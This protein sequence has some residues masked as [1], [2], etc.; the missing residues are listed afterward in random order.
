MSGFKGLVPVYPNRP[1]LPSWQDSDPNSH[2]I[3]Q[4]FID[5]R[6]GARFNPWTPQQTQGLGKPVTSAATNY[7]GLRRFTPKPQVDNSFMSNKNHGWFSPLDWQGASV[8]TEKERALLFESTP[9]THKA[10]LLH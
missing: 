9:L 4:A 5:A 2:S 6:G 3:P 1:T 7:E 8:L 10:S